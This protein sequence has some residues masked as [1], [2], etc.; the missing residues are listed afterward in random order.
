MT[1][2]ASFRVCAERGLGACPQRRSAGLAPAGQG[3]RFAALRQV[4]LVC[5]QQ[6]DF[7]EIRAAGLASD[8]DVLTAGSDLDE[9]DDAFDPGRFVVEQS[10]RRVDGVVGTKDRS[11]LLAALI[12]ERAGL[13][14]PTPRALIA[15]QHKP[16][17]RAL[18]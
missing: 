15:C 12:A 8:F 7:R 4:L 3:V 5:P 10:M 6:R 1:G 14:G 9:H 16:T 2:A 11:A 17:S 18:A 13:A